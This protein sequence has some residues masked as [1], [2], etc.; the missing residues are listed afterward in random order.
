MTREG[1]SMML[2]MV[3]MAGGDWC[4]LALAISPYAV[5]GGGGGGGGGGLYV[6]Q[7]LFGAIYKL[8]NAFFGYFKDSST[9]WIKLI[10]LKT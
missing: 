5:E 4:S 7:L 9:P 8:C 6:L 3:P 1:Q 2:V 10:F